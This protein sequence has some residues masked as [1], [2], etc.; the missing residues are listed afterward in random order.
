MRIMSDD[1]GA[2]DFQ[3]HVPEPSELA[4]ATIPVVAHVGEMSMFVSL[5]AVKHDGYGDSAY[6][7]VEQVF[8]ERYEIPDPEAAK[9][10]LANLTSFK[11]AIKQIVE[12]HL[13]RTSLSD[14]VSDVWRHTYIRESSR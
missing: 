5:T 14:L 11:K 2:F 10:P 6:A 12:K 7:Y 13:F 1:A 3:A 4:S 9:Q 8:L